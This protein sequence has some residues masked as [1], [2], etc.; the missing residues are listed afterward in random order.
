MAAGQSHKIPSVT[1]FNYGSP[2]ARVRM[3]VGSTATVKGGKKGEHIR[4]KKRT[5]I[6]EF[7]RSSLKLLFVCYSSLV[8]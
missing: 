5:L 8:T 6:V 4:E 2:Y 7:P 1:A 3:S